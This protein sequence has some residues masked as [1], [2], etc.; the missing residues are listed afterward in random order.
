MAVKKSG[1]RAVHGWSKL[2][3]KRAG[4]IGPG[5]EKDPTKGTANPFTAHLKPANDPQSKKSPRA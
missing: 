1:T 5:Y 3:E 4:S 2:E